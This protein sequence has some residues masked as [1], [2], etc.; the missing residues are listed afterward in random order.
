MTPLAYLRACTLA[1]VCQEGAAAPT[2]TPSWVATARVTGT[3]ASTRTTGITTTSSDL[4]IL[5]ESPIPLQG[6]GTCRAALPR[7]AL[8]KLT[9]TPTSSRAIR[10]MQYGGE[11]SCAKILLTS[12]GPQG[13]VSTYDRRTG[14][15]ACPVASVPGVL[16]SHPIAES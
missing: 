12:D 8:D 5:N 11:G 13:D 14:R 2:S 7:P 4:R 3:M 16:P 1:F 10:K 15:G 9:L 6:A